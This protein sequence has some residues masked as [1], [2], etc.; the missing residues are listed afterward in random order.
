MSVP[1]GTKLMVEVEHF[2]GTMEIVYYDTFHVEDENKLFRV[3]I[4]GND[5]ER[6]TIVDSMSN[7]NGAAF[8]T[9]DRDNVNIRQFGQEL[10]CAARHGAGW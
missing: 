4:S 8:S 7:M 5:S 1:G 9:K 3:T 6:S 2:N 10:H